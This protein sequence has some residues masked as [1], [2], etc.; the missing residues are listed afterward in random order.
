MTSPSLADKS[1]HVLAGQRF[2]LSIACWPSRWPYQP[3][4]SPRGDGTRA[5]AP[6]IVIH[7]LDGIPLYNGDVETGAPHRAWCS[8]AT[9]FGRQ[10]GYIAEHNHGVP[11]VLKNTTDWLSRPP[12]NGVLNGTVA[13]LMGACRV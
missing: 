12:R 7:E 9:L 4:T 2:P 1:R 6:H 13:A 10:M 8:L 11:G 3:R 5:V